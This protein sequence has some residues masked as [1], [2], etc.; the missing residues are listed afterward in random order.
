MCVGGWVGGA[1]GV[2]GF[3]GVI[4]RRGTEGR[5][6]VFYFVNWSVQMEMSERPEKRMDLIVEMPP[7]LPND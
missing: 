1:G 5:E 7:L 6:R 4:A 2:W 3:R